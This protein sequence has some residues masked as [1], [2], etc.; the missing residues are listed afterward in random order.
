MS[1]LIVVGSSFTFLTFTSW[2]SVL[3]WTSVFSWSSVLSWTSVFSWS[4]VSV[5][6]SRL[7]FTLD[8]FLF[9]FLG[10]F[11]FLFNWSLLSNNWSF[12]NLLSNWNLF[13]WLD[14]FWFWDNDW[15]GLLW[16]LDL[17]FLYWFWLN[18]LFS[19]LFNWLNNLILSNQS[20]NRF[21]KF[22]ITGKSSQNL[23]DVFSAFNQ[24][25]SRFLSKCFVQFSKFI[26]FFPVNVSSQD[27]D[28]VSELVKFLEL[29]VSVLL[30]VFS[31][32]LSEEISDTFKSASLL[33]IFN[34]SVNLF[35]LFWFEI[36]FLFKFI[37][38]NEFFV[39]VSNP[40]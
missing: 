27:S 36:T 11:S 24:R 33:F 4:S 12:F 28:S 22:K 31:I 14:N 13:N 39:N 15:L 5:V 6:T 34:S 19:F 21:F 17:S 18:W 23:G 30:N 20:F 25:D 29:V 16:F 9:T 7:S 8:W 3:S 37:N 32:S 1:V 26:S 2:S 38:F 40:L 10:L 35:N